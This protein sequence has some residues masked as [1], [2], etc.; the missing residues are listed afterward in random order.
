MTPSPHPRRRNAKIKSWWD[1]ESLGPEPAGFRT[2]LE[3]VFRYLEGKFADWDYA[4]GR[5]DYCFRFD[6]EKNRLSLW[7]EQ[8]DLL[9]TSPY[10]LE[11]DASLLGGDGAAAAGPDFFRP[12]GE[13]FRL[14]VPLIREAR[15]KS[16]GGAS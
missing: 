4:V 7:V 13:T 9:D 8:G 2:S 1:L 14:W 3:P 15:Q 16:G 10:P 11:I 6:G 12:L 5:D